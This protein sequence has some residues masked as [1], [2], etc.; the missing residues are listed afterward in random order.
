MR[1]VLVKVYASF[2]P[3]KE[4][5]QKALAGACAT[6]LGNEDWLIFDGDMLRIS[7]EGLYFPL[8]EALQALKTELEPQSAGRLDYL[9]L[10]A[11]TLTRCLFEG[12][13]F[14][15]ST[16]SLNHVLAYSGH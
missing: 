2:C 16:R 15:I 1:Q 12:G 5:A 11:W 4:T 10:E 8:D 13:G 9:D 7:F 14:S 6:A 3:A